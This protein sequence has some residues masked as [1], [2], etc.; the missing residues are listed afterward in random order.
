MILIG[1][2]SRLVGTVQCH[3]KDVVV[4]GEFEGTLISSG[5]LAVYRN[6]MV[7]G[8]IRVHNLTVAGNIQGEVQVENRLQVKSSA[9]VRA[10]ITTAKLEW[11]E[12]AN[13]QGE[14]NCVL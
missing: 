8:I 6:G 13:L 14:I 4:A 10:C 1:E 2:K 12:G 7:S 9:K 11:E 3:E 5:E